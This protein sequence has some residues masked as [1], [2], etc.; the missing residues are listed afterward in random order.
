MATG[1]ISYQNVSIKYG[2]LVGI[3]H[4]VYF[5]IMGV[6]GLHDV[7]EL[8][9]ISGLF[10]VIGII[11]AISKFKRLSHG[12]IRYFEGL[13]IGATVGVVSSVILAIFLAIYISVFDATYL[14]NL[15]ASALF[16]ESISL[17]SLMLL[18]VIYGTIPGFFIAFIAMQWF[19][20][21]GH[22]MPERV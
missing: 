20:R 2:I 18:T 8:S 21:E 14:E 1:K 15:Q 11:I 19:K 12:A 13:G 5:L 6:L 10:L 9:F 22:S 4:I 3:A 16:P 17:L 7:I